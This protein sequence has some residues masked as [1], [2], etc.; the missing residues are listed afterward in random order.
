MYGAW[1]DNKIPLTE[2]ARFRPNPEFSFAVAKAEAE[3]VVAEWAEDHP[4]AHVAILRPA[5]TVGSPERPLYQAL[6]VTRS[7]GSG[8]GGRPVQYLHVDDLADGGGTGVG[9]AAFGRVQ[10]GARL[11]HPRG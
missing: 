8:D 2:D 7:P 4:D 10:R 5:V 6:G 11:R 9:E 1:P 3:R